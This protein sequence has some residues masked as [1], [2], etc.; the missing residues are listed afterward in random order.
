MPRLYA[1]LICA[2]LCSCSTAG[3]TSPEQPS[4]TSTSTTQPA[5]TPVELPELVQAC[6]GTNLDLTWVATAE[7][8]VAPRDQPVLEPP[9]NL[10]A[11]L[12]PAK[13][14]LEPG[15]VTQVDYVLSNPG[16]AAVTFDLAALRCTTEEFELQI[17]DRSGERADFPP[18]RCGGGGGCSMPDA[19]MT[20]D[21]GGDA[22][23]R[24]ELRAEYRLTNDD[25]EFEDPAPL[26]PNHYTLEATPSPSFDAPFAL[27]AVRGELEVVAK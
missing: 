6:A 23:I 7:A 16:D 24:L 25:C 9:E 12:E 15:A 27:E 20:L 21:P 18:P 13:L 3:V 10:A 14:V 8:C 1:S 26:A 22:R 5:S 19:R 2:A 11:R 17:L 4:S